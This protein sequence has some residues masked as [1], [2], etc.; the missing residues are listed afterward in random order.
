MPLET[1]LAL[2]TEDDSNGE[3]TW[4]NFYDGKRH[5]SFS[6]R[7]HRKAWQYLQDRAP[8]LV[9]ACNMEYDLVNLYGDW[10][11]KLTTL[12]YTNS[13]FFRATATYAPVQFYDTLRHWPGVSVKRMGEFLGI[14]K[15]PFDPDSLEYCRLD[16]RIVWEFVAGMLERYDGLRLSL[17]STLPSMAFQFWKKH[18]SGP[19]GLP[20]AMN[21]EF[22][23]GYYG[24]RVECFYLGNFTSEVR[25]YDFTSLY[26]A[27][28]TSNFPHPSWWRWTT[29][30]DWERDGMVWCLLRV[31][32]FLIPPLPVRENGELLFPT[33][34]IYG[35][36]T[37][38]EVR[39]AMLAGVVIEQVR[40]A[41]EFRE[42]CSPFYDYIHRCTREKDRSEGI[43]R[44]FWKL[45]M[46]SLYGKFGQESALTI[47]KDGREHT[48]TPNQPDHVNVLWAAM[49]TARARVKLWR[50]MLEANPLYYCDTDSLFTERPLTTGGGLGMLR[51]VA[52]YRGGE[53]F[54]NKCYVVEGKATA[55]GIPKPRE[56]GDGDFPLQ[57][58]YAGRTLF[59]KP[60][61]LREARKQG[62][63]PN[64]WYLESRVRDPVYRKRRG[65]PG[66][67]KP[68]DLHQY[69]EQAL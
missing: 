38:E 58:L 48:F 14:K 31:P 13:G 12:Q 34:R 45:L 23:D 40:G 47:L 39:N 18:Y 63:V 16:T 4:I 67:T 9:F 8:I 32:E 20:H 56:E 3:V 52:T 69:R 15:L 33:G 27:V 50:A 46:N 62:L 37:Y 11:D 54:G 49:I 68:W 24:G 30:P 2:D 7:E 6:G 55:K 21:T 42:T 19:S 43:D 57:F 53:F 22:R 28:M 29:K 59:R 17:K 35:A 66:F 44:E 10:V 65:G 26:P 36:W 41:Y 51:E 60:A 1:F 5:R 61:R 25:H 64:K